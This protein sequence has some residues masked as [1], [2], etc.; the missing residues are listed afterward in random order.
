MIALFT[1][2]GASVSL[3][4]PLDKNFNWFMSFYQ[5]LVTYYLHIQIRDV[6]T[7]TEF[8]DIFLED[9]YCILV[10][11]TGYGKPLSQLSLLERDELC[12]TVKDYHTQ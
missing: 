10:A 7:V 6:S 2:C 11:E 8:R 12:K 4:K 3:C 1:H 9:D 5:H